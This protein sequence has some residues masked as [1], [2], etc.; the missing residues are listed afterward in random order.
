MCKYCFSTPEIL[1]NCFKAHLF[2]SFLMI[3]EN[4][5]ISTPSFGNSSETVKTSGNGEDAHEGHKRKD[6]FRPSVLD[7]ESGRRD[8]WRDEER[9]TKF[10]IRKD[11]WRDGD[12]D[13]GDTQRV[14]R[15]T[16]NP[17]PRH[18]GE[19]RRGTPDRL[20]G[21]GNKEM[22]LDQRRENSW[23]DGDKDLGDARRVDRWTES[24]STRHFGET[25]RGTLDRSNDSGNREMIS[26]QQRESKWNTRWGLDDKEPEVLR[27]KW[28]DSGKNDNLHLDKGLS[29]RSTPGKDEKEGDHHLPWRPN[30]SQSRGRVEPSHY[31]NVTP[32]KQVPMFSSGRG[33]G[34]DTPPVINLGRARFGSGGSPINRTYLHSQYSGT[35]S[36]KIENEYGEAHPFRYSRSNILDVYRVTNV[37]TDR[38]LVDDF[39]QVPSLTQDEPLEPLAICAPTSEEL[40]IDVTV[41]CFWMPLSFVVVY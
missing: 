7:S 1:Y 30:S 41:Y 40:V 11:R 18:F 8:C 38:K 10:S 16:E 23:K 35:V 2:Y 33:R 22:N 37:H 14:H 24:P 9:D 3:Q 4:N 26:D 5:V 27:E 13:L 36:D 34:E 29:H 32:N 6:V 31:Q 25:R 21:S 19:T 39:V 12:K 17:S 28:N 20:N 15:W